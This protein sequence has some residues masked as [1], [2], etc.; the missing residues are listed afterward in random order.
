[1]WVIRL[2]NSAGSR[3]FLGAHSLFTALA[4][5]AHRYH[6]KSDAENVVAALAAS[7][8]RDVTVEKL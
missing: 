7:G 6:Y 8:Y 4:E 2:K 3:G 1:M 5:R